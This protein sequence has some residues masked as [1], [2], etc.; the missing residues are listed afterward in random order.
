MHRVAGARMGELE[1]EMRGG[2][3][4]SANV[5]ESDAGRRE[6][7]EGRPWIRIGHPPSSCFLKPSPGPGFGPIQA[8]KSASANALPSIVPFAAPFT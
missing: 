3:K 6:R 7:P 5:P 2:R 8:L 4:A 1:G